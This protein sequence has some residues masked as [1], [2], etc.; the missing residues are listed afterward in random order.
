MIEVHP[1]F[2]EAPDLRS[3]IPY[4]KTDLSKNQ[5][6]SRRITP[7]PQSTKRLVSK[8]RLAF[9]R[10]GLKEPRLSE[11]KKAEMCC[12]YRRTGLNPN[13]VESAPT[14]V[15]T[16]RRP[17]TATTYPH[18]GR[19][20]RPL[21]PFRVLLR[22]VVDRPH[23]HPGLPRSYVAMGG[24]RCRRS[25]GG[26]GGGGGAWCASPKRK[27][28]ECPVFVLYRVPSRRTHWVKSM[29]ERG[30]GCTPRGCQQSESENL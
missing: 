17:T 4:P 30:G 11:T 12:L 26:G 10:F 20:C 23:R 22:L 6:A 7:W 18:G 5:L 2:S 3:S 13:V 16:T 19:I 15:C 21:V 24:L 29:R 28:L 14:A 8:S 25:G 1:N 9:R 27:L